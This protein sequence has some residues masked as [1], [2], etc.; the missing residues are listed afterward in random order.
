MKEVHLFIL[1][2]N[3][4]NKEKEILNDIKSSF[5]IIGMYNIKWEKDTFSENLT[6]FYGTNLPKNSYKEE[7]CG[8]GDF[9]LIVVEV[10][11]PIYEERETSK[12]LQI[13]NTNMF[14]KK[15]LYREMTGGGHK[16]HA[17]NSETETN[18][19]L[20]LLLGKNINDYLNE[21]ETNNE[22]ECINLDRELTGKDGFKDVKEMFYVLNNCVNYAIIRNYESL[23]DEIYIND[24]NDIDIICDNLE[25]TAYILNGEK[26]FPEEYRVHYKVKVEN[27]YVFFDIRYVGDNYYYYKIEKNILKDRVY[28][29]KGFYTISECDYFYT[30]AYH[31]IIQKYEFANDYKNRL[32]KMNPTNQKLSDDEKFIKLL[33]N[34]LI[35]NGYAII[36]PNDLSVVFN[37]NMVNRF[38]NLLFIDNNID[39]VKELEN[40]NN[41]LKIKLNQICNSK[42]WK[43]T[44]PLRN[45]VL[46]LKK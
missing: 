22:I 32:I 17:T 42:S 3:A 4:R 18:H 38:D 12:G 35:Q 1:W 40:E 28:N 46:K 16:V 24:H 43:V 34:W 15:S 29:E 14:D 5:R 30:L 27:K 36:K 13:V 2:E 23:P 8:N 25:D 44:Q 11:N 37:M 45:I 9:L 33:N 7:H 10:D 26:V 31:A 41:S 19:D 6:R 39:R 21:L 20:T